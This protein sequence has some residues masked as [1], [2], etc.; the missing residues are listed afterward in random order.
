[1]SR[2]VACVVFRERIRILGPSVSVEYR[3]ANEKILSVKFNVF[4]VDVVD[5]AVINF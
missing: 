2:F 4:I 1:M 3:V 5:V